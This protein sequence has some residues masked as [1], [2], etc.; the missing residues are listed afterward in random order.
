MMILIPDYIGA[1]DD[2]TYESE[3]LNFK[4]KLYSDLNLR[5][6]KNGTEN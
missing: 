2:L 3:F 5:F 4:N 1:S 6:V